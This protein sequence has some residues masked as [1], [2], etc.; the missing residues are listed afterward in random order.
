VGY[1]GLEGHDVQDAERD[2]T[3]SVGVRTSDDL[4]ANGENEREA[5]SLSCTQSI[6]V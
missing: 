3:G 5:V 2:A 4:T 6:R 1:D